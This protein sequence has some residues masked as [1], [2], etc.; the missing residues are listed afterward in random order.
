[1]FLS[2][3]HQHIIIAVEL[4]FA[5]VV[6]PHAGI[7]ARSNHPQ[8]SFFPW[9]QNSCGSITTTSTWLGF[10]LL[11]YLLWQIFRIPLCLELATLWADILWLVALVHSFTDWFEEHRELPKHR[12]GDGLALVRRIF[13]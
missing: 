10:P 11:S 8:I 7:D 4:F 1:M 13:A 3:V 12:H 9:I 2:V 5:V 6:I